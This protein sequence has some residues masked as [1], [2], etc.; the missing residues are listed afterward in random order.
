[1]S[2][3]LSQTILV[4]SGVLIAFGLFNISNHNF[5]SVEVPSAIFEKFTLWAKEQNK[6]YSSPEEL[7]FRL[8]VFYKNFLKIVKSNNEHTSFKLGLNK[9]ADM[10]LEEAKAKL[11]GLQQATGEKV[12]VREFENVEDLPTEVNWVTFGAVTPV[13]NQ[14]N[15]GSCWSFSST[16]ALEGL[17]FI[18]NKDLQS[19]SE[20][21]LVDCDHLSFG[22]FGGSMYRAF[23]YVQAHG[24]PL[25]Q[26]YPYVAKNERCK[27]KIPGPYFK[28]TG[29]VSVKEDEGQLM[30]AIALQPVS[31][32][33]EADEIVHYT[34]GIFNN[35][36]CKDNLDHGV[37]AVGYGTTTDGKDYW[38]VKN[39]WGP[40]W[41]EA[42]YI[43]FARS[44]AQPNVCGILEQSLYP[45]LN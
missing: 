37:L 4:L 34:T 19:Y 28:N 44:K 36:D 11:F 42:G 26:N 43:R 35:P 8:G 21:F 17:N 5:E 32:A 23:E 39:S 12:E 31:I 45:T 10:T 25:E 6:E 2:S 24:I 29:I 30:A 22:C 27:K 7:Q 33:I 16:G 1:M 9:F 13:K 40:D 3:S 41:G 38:L 14:G 18:K 15:C 20:Q